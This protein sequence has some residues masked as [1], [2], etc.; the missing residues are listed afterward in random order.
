MR[1][2]N[3]HLRQ[4]PRYI[5]LRLLIWGPRFEN[6]Q[7]TRCVLYVRCWGQG[8]GIAAWL[9]G[10]SAAASRKPPLT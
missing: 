1:L 4:D 7:H 2:E 8:G 5:L 6:L 9:G 10:V 3:L